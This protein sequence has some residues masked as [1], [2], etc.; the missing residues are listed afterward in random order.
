MFKSTKAWLAAKAKGNVFTRRRKRASDSSPS[1]LRRQSQTLLSSTQL[2]SSISVKRSNRISIEEDA[3]ADLHQAAEPNFTSDILSDGLLGKHPPQLPNRILFLTAPS[4]DSETHPP[5]LVEGERPRDS[6]IDL[7]RRDDLVDK[8]LHSDFTCT[9]TVDDLGFWNFSIIEDDNTGIVESIEDNGHV[10]PDIHRIEE[11]LRSQYQLSH[12]GSNEDYFVPIDQ[13]YRILCPQQVLLYLRYIFPDELEYS[14]IAMTDKICNRNDGGMRRILATLILIGKQKAIAELIRSELIDE[15]LPLRWHRIND[16]GPLVLS[17]RRQRYDED[18]GQHL[19]LLDWPASSVEAFH[20]TQ[21]VFTVPYFD[22]SADRLTFYRMDS[23]VVLPFTYHARRRM[24]GGYGTVS[25]VSMHPAHVG[26]GSANPDTENTEPTYYAIKQLRSEDYDE[27]RVEMQ[28]LERF[29]GPNRGHDHL[30]RLCMAF[31]RGNR[32]FFVFPWADG[33]LSDLWERKKVSPNSKE[34]IEWFAQQSLGIVQAVRKLHKHSS[35]TKLRGRFNADADKYRGRHGDIKPENILYFETET[36]QHPRLV[37]TDFGG[38]QFFTKATVDQIPL[39]RVGGITFTYRGPEIDLDAPISQSSDIWGLGCV[40]LEFISWLL[41]GIQAR[42]DFAKARL[43]G[44]IPAVP[45]YALLEDKFFHLEPSGDDSNGIHIA[46]LKPSVQAWIRMLHEC[47][48]CS[49]FIHEFLDL[50]EFEMLDPSGKSRIRID[51]L[52]FKIVVMITRITKNFEYA[53]RATPWIPRSMTQ[54]FASGHLRPIILPRSGGLSNGTGQAST[55]P[56]SR[57]TMMRD[58]TIELSNKKMHQ[59]KALS[60]GIARYMMRSPEIFG[61]KRFLPAD[62][63]AELVT[64]DVVAYELKAAGVEPT[65][66]LVNFALGDA[67]IVFLTLYNTMN[68][69]SLAAAL[70]D[71]LTDHRLPIKKTL[72]AREDGSFRWIVED[73]VGQDPGTD[74]IGLQQRNV[75]SQWTPLQVES[76]VESQWLFL[77]PILGISDHPCTFQANTPMPFLNAIRYSNTMYKT[78]VHPSHINAGPTLHRDRAIPVVAVRM[79]EPHLP[80]EFAGELTMLQE[81]EVLQHPK[82]LRPIAIYKTGNV[83]GIMFPWASRGNLRHYWAR[84]LNGSWIYDA[85]D[86]NLAALILSQATGL[87]DALAALEARGHCH[88]NL[89]PENILDFSIDDTTPNLVLTDIG[90]APSYRLDYMTYSV[91]TTHRKLVHPT[92]SVTRSYRNAARYMPP[93]YTPKQSL[94]SSYDV[95]ALGSILLEYVILGVLGENRFNTFNMWVTQFW[96]IRDG[97]NQLH[98]SASAI[99]D[100]L[101]ENTKA[102]PALQ[103]LLSFIGTRMLV[104]SV[105]ETGGSEGQTRAEMSEVAEWMHHQCAKREVGT[106]NLR[107]IPAQVPQKRAGALDHSH[108]KDM[109]SSLEPNRPGCSL[110]SRDGSKPDDSESI[111]TASVTLPKEA[112]MFPLTMV[113]ESWRLVNLIQRLARPKV[114]PHRERLE[115]TCSCGMEMYGD[116]C[117]S[118]PAAL[119][120]LSAQLHHLYPS[121]TLKRSGLTAPGTSIQLLPSWFF[122]MDRYIRQKNPQTQGQT[123]NPPTGAPGLTSTGVNPQSNTPGHPMIS[124]QPLSNSAP[125]SIVNRNINQG[126]LTANNHIP[127]FLELCV[128]ID[129]Y[130]IRLGEIPLSSIHTDRGLFDEIWKRYC[131]IRGFGVRRLFVKPS[132]INFIRFGVFHRKT[133]GIYAKPS[134]IPPPEEVKKQAYHYFECPL[135]SL[136]PIP[137]NV[138]LHYLRCAQRE[139]WSIK[140]PAAHQENV[141][142]QRLPKKMGASIWQQPTIST[143]ASQAISYGWGVHIIEGPNK[144]TMSL[145]L[146]LGTLFSFLTSVLFVILAHSQEQ[147]FGIGQWILAVLAEV[148]AA[149][150][151]HFSEA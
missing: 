128:N 26:T 97:S 82:V 24:H 78:W 28:N 138:F 44:D 7:S 57:L 122:S 22:M 13:L 29:S 125:S 67:R 84:K 63:I 109:Q 116:F 151:F 69:Q 147:G 60:D 107:P 142:L 90:H 83:Q 98:A 74:E 12:W 110:S 115:W 103:D 135:E 66:A 17:R 150:Y 75:F 14:I 18:D 92:Y 49:D 30:I 32:F 25:Q 48:H 127:T 8:D 52:Y 3:T 41:L 143:T 141:F 85:Q 1:G 94:S 59:S 108:S 100:E 101:T 105:T 91:T 5:I 45:P 89:K 130:E 77:A 31:Q 104:V 96:D 61:G 133:V 15:D 136:P 54:A 113:D 20:R 95:W 33:N 47:D 4:D 38:V 9:T 88:G 42:H 139:D 34:D 79:F 70:S 86:S 144:K 65:D 58:F 68:L 37:L 126:L 112:T 56:F 39:N 81:K 148:L 129:S 2:N 53:V 64:K 134:A 6:S 131:D 62:R 146:I 137:A 27:F 132:D 16:S 72:G 46:K 10:G 118:S 117:K 23:D 111:T 21:Y 119:E 43:E 123:A 140:H 51:H 93:E 114:P 99:L 40:Y 120:R 87:A 106:D 11:S 71:N 36:P 55:D 102:Q 149:L 50:I 76:F 124:S 73:S 80:Q 145:L 35:W 19:I 121:A